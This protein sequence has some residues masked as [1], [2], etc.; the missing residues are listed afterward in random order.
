MSMK[1]IESTG[2]GRT[3]RLSSADDGLLSLC[4]HIELGAPCGL[5][6]TQLAIL[7]LQRSHHGLVGEIDLCSARENKVRKA[8]QYKPAASALARAAS[9]VT[10]PRLCHIGSFSK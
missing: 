8:W 9:A 3:A 1:Q 7:C 5:P 6:L 4:E 10:C 2:I